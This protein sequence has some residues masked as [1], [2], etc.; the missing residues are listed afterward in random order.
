MKEVWHDVC[1]EPHLQ[2][3]TGEELSGHTNIMGDESRLE[4]SAQGFLEVDL[5][6]HSRI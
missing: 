2:P 4:V 3:L 1:F 6:G 5:K